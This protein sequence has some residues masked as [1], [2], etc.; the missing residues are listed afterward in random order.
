MSR[1]AIIRI[2]I[3]GGAVGLLEIACRIGLISNFDMIPPSMMVYYLVL[4]I[5]RGDLIGMGAL[6]TFQ[7]ITAAFILAL[8]VGVTTGIILHR[9]PSLR[10][11]L[12]PLFAAYYA[13]PIFAFYPM[14]VVLMGLDGRPQIIIGFLLGVV[15]VIVN[16]LNGLDRVPRALLKTGRVLRMGRWRTA[17]KITIP[18]AMPY[19]FTG[20]KLAVA[21]SFTGIIGSEFILASAGLGFDISFAYNT[22]NNNVMYPLILFVLL[23]ATAINMT[24]YHWEKIMFQ[25]RRG[26]S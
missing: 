5:V 16:T 7:D 1:A 25:R 19:I 21:Y 15:A 22:F 20:I 10:R 23:V 14:F 4:M 11:T 13:V 2:L 12:D 8:T 18:A 24:F 26:R 3:L 17:W 6:R 9:F